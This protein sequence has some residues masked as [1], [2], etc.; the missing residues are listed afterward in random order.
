MWTLL[1]TIGVISNVFGQRTS[2]PA[3]KGLDSAFAMLVC[4]YFALWAPTGIYTFTQSRLPKRVTIIQFF[5]ILPF[6]YIAIPFITVG[7]IALV[8]QGKTD[9]P[10]AKR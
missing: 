7:I 5:L 1:V 9:P 4:A 2:D 10:M 6:F 3:S 8:L